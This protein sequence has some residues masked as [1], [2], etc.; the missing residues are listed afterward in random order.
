MLTVAL[1][2]SSMVPKMFNPFRS[3]FVFGVFFFVFFFL[4][5][6]GELTLYFSPSGK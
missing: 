5:F 1:E 3:F 6:T 2:H 4:G